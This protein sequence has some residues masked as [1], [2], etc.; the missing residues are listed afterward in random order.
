MVIKNK[1]YTILGI[2]FMV[3]CLAS[4]AT[5]HNIWMIIPGFVCGVLFLAFGLHFK[6]RK[7]LQKSRLHKKELQSE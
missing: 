7:E 4:F 6:D 2:V 5:M 3:L 1:S